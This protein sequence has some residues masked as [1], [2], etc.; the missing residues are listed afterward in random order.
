MPSNVL[1]A[2]N[3][4]ADPFRLVIVRHGSAAALLQRQTWLRPIESLNLALLIGA[5]YDCVFRWV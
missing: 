5:E 2:A 3:K 4:V 1:S